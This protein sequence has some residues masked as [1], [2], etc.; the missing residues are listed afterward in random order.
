[1]N[2]EQNLGG[3]KQVKCCGVMKGGCN[4]CNT[5]CVMY[6]FGVVGALVYFLQNAE[7][8]WMGALGILKAIAWPG[9]V[10]YKVLELLQF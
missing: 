8:F 6:C 4:K 2:N 9:L 7:T 10:M 1:M 5:G 3:E